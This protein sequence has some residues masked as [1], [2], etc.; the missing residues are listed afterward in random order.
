MNVKGWGAFISGRCKVCKGKLFGDHG[1]KGHSFKGVAVVFGA[2]IGINHMHRRGFGTVRGGTYYQEHAQLIGTVNEGGVGA[3]GF[4]EGTKGNIGRASGFA[5]I[6]A[7][8]QTVNKAICGHVIEG[9]CH[10]TGIFM[11]GTI[12]GEGIGRYSIRRKRGI[13]LGI[14]FVPSD[15][16]GFERL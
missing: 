4:F 8:K 12:G 2:V 10:G 1:F 13:A 15:T 11:Q 5:V 14:G 3:F 9:A 6:L 16:V 7:D